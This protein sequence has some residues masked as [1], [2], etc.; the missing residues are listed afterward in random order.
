MA[1]KDLN[2]LDHLDELRK[3]LIIIAI[4]FVVFFLIGFL[5]VEPIYHWFV[6]GLDTQLI[7]LGPGE[8]IW[9]YFKLASIIAIAGT[10]PVFALQLWLFVKP[11]LK[12]NE[13][14][15]TLSYVPGLFVLFILGLCFGYYVI[16]PSIMHFL[17]ELS[18]DMFV[19][20]FTAEK[21]FSFL[22]NMTLPIAL[23]F[24]LPVIVMFLTSIGLLNPKV[25]S[26]FRKYAYFILIII[27][28]MITPPDF[29]SNI[30][31]SIP[32]ILLY[33]I[34]ISL[35]RIVYKKRQKRLNSE[36]DF[37]DYEEVK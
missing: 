25:L 4:A 26:K 5:N 2:M 31:V 22:I 28:A 34:S 1:D 6:R 23:V 33:E 30:L 8:I 12:K 18:G 35:S 29:I 15:L 14:R 37:E 36:V 20:N 11:A 32:L 16:F 24:E 10:I 17:I 3:R 13:I 19:T 9:V 21:Y 7:V 27:A